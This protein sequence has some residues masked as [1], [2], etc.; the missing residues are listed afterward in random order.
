[1]TNFTSAVSESIKQLGQSFLLAYYLPAAVFV[2]LHLYLLIPIW[3]GAPASFLTMTTLVTLPLIGDV[4]L[5]TLIGTLV[6]PFLVGIVLTGLNDVLIR[7]FEGKLGWLR[8]GLLYPLARFNTK[9]CERLYGNLVKFRQKYWEISAEWL[10]AEST[11]AQLSCQQKL[12]GLAEQIKAEQNKLEQEHGWQILPHAIYR[13][14][15]TSFGNVYALAEEYAYDRYGIDAVL[16]WPRLRGLMQDKATSHSDRITQQ[17]TALD[18][19]LNFA[20][21]CGLLTLEAALTARFGPP[22]HDSLLL[23]LVFLSA[24]LAMSFY[25]AS[26][27][28]VRL[29]GE[30]IKISFDYH[31]DLVLESFNLKRPGQLLAERAVWVRLAAF[32]RRGDE[33]YFPSE[34]APTTPG[35]TSSEPTTTSSRGIDTIPSWRTFLK[36]LFLSIYILLNRFLQHQ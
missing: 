26:V 29:L 28:A 30:L 23:W 9:R 1:M 18:L 2:L 15:P 24:L 4:D 5:A 20:F 6:L 19:S 25:S 10:R 8:W 31:R 17:K 14:A 22:G 11:E 12:A 3:V 16:F 33:F 36:N 35:S 13:V 27:S 32:V 21:I 7:L 34:A